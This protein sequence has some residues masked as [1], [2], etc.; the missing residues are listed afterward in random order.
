[1]GAPKTGFILTWQASNWIFYTLLASAWFWPSLSKSLSFMSLNVSFKCLNLYFPAVTLT[2]LLSKKKKKKSVKIDLKAWHTLNHT[3]SRNCDVKKLFEISSTC[4]LREE[5][6]GS[7]WKLGSKRAALLS[8]AFK[9]GQQFSFLSPCWLSQLD[10]GCTSGAIR[11]CNSCKSQFG[12]SETMATE[13]SL[14]CFTFLFLH[15][16][17]NGAHLWSVRTLKDSIIS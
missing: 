1:M 2:F 14:K 10:A 7:I 5:L 12:W 6:R 4:L 11:T 13:W 16:C 17:E 3:S 15:L 8:I 9:S